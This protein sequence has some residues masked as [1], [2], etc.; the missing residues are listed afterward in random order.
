M[1]RAVIAPAA[2]VDQDLAIDW[3]D[4]GRFAESISVAR[5]ELF[6]PVEA[7]RKRFALG[8]RGVWIIGLVATGRVRVQSDIAR[9]W[10][11]GRSTVAE[12]IAPLTRAGLVTSYP[13][14]SD[15]RQIRLELTA[16]GLAFN[17]ELGH[18][19][20]DRI[21]DRLAGYRPEDIALC[22]RMLNDLAGPGRKS[23]FTDT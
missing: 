11:I 8:P 7:F 6:A 13:D 17:Q 4:I 9:L 22:I 16:A 14:T 1:P 3:A 19:F 2:N 18:L 5:K 20:A 12:E 15:R 21:N 10:R 23:R